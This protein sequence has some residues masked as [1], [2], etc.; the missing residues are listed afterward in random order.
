MRAEGGDGDDRFIVANL[1]GHKILDGGLGT[2]ELQLEYRLGVGLEYL[3]GVTIDLSVTSDQE[4]A[5]GV[6]IA[7]SSIERVLGSGGSDRLSGGANSEAISGL[8]GNDILMGAGGDDTLSGGDGADT[9]IGGLGRDELSGGWAADLFVFAPGDGSRVADRADI[10]SDWTPEDHIRFT[11]GPASTSRNFVEIEG[12]DWAAV[13]V[14]VDGLFK[15]VGARYVAVKFGLD[16]F[17]FADTG[18]EGETYDTL[19]KLQGVSTAATSSD[20]IIGI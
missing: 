2:D 11:D 10:I 20:M 19:I 13:L 1:A 7:V 4:I 17:L 5:S 8:D 3:S 6:F 18:V 14:A 15:G 12:T 16:T 9:L